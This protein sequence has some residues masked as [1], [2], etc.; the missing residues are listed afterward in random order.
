MLNFMPVEIYNTIDNIILLLV[1]TV[2]LAWF[3]KGLYTIHPQLIQYCSI[4]YDGQWLENSSGLL[5]GNSC[6]RR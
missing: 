2:L 4:C 6:K 1:I 5:A 3:E